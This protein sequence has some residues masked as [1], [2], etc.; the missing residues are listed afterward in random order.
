MQTWSATVD[1]VLGRIEAK[2]HVDEEI[3]SNRKEYTCIW[4]LANDGRFSAGLTRQHIDDQLF[5]SLNIP[6]SWDKALP[7]KVNIFMWLLKLDR[8]PHRLNLP[9]RGIENPEIILPLLIYFCRLV[10]IPQRHMSPGKS[11]SPVLIFLVVSLH[12]IKKGSST[13]VEFAR[14]FKAIC[15]QLNAIGHPL[16]DTDKSHWFL[17][18]LGSSFETFST[19]QCLIRPRPSFCDLVSQAENHELF[20]QTVN[21][22]SVQPVAFNTSTTRAFTGQQTEHSSSCGR[23]HNNYSNRGVSSRGRG[24]GYRR[25]PQCQL[26]GKESHYATKC[27]DLNTFASRPAAIDANLAHAFQAQCNVAPESP[28][29][30]VDS[31]ASS[32]MTSTTSNLDSASTYVGNEFIIFAN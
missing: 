28:D 16:D 15:D 27:P 11:P 20:L 22:S 24:R 31:G 9:S 1:F 23:G 21:A 4:S 8:L 10:H 6:T 25:L 26:C 29:W 32:H 2:A 7:R 14:K 17:C 3:C 19:T 18:G 5:P 12:E 13:I 30:F